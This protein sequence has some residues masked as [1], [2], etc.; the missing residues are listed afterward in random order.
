MA[1]T[2]QRTLQGLDHGVLLILIDGSVL[3]EAVERGLRLLS[4]RPPLFAGGALDDGLGGLDCAPAG[5]TVLMAKAPAP[6]AATMPMDP[7]SFFM[8]TRMAG[9][10]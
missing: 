4:A 10:C 3:H 7:R 5:S 9:V 6:R 2:G 1:L 8:Q